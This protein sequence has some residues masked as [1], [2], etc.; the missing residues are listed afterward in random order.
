[1]SLM[2]SGTQSCAREKAKARNMEWRLPQ[3][4][5]Y[6]LDKDATHGMVSV[7]YPGTWGLTGP[8][9]NSV[10]LAGFRN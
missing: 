10:V 7:N 9:I 5:I 8:A 4:N 3:T 6:L 1:M 2:G